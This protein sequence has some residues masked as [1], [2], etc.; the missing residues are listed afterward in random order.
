MTKPAPQP[1]SSLADRNGTASTK[2]PQIQAVK[3]GQQIDLS[4]P[5]QPRKWSL[6]AKATTLALALS[7]LPVLGVGTVSYL[8]NQSIKTQVSK[9]T[10]EKEFRQTE[11][12]LE[13][14]L[15]WVLLSTGVSAVVAG[16]V[17][18]LLVS[19]AVRRVLNAA[20]TSSSLVNRLGRE[21]VEPGNSVVGDEIVALETNVK[22]IERQLPDLLWRQE[23][24]AER[25]KMLMN[26]TRRIWQSLTEADVYKTTTEA[27]RTALK[28]ERVVI[29]RF[30]SNK[31]GTFIEE[32]VAS[33]YS[34][35]LWATIDGAFFRL[36]DIEQYRKNHVQAIDNIY[37][38]GKTDAQIGLW[39]RF[40]IKAHL[41]APIIKDNQLF[42]LLIVHQCSNPREW[43]QSEIDLLGHLATQ[44]GYALK[45]VKLVEQVDTKAKLAQVFIDITQRIRESLN[46]EDIL[47]TTVEEVRKA[48]R[49]E[50]VI[51]YSFD[52]DW[53]GTVSAESVLP[54]FPKALWAAIKDPCFAEGY[55]DKYQNGRVQATNNVYAAGLTECHLKQLEPFGVKANLV[56]PILKDG[57]LFGLLIAHQC[58]SPRDWQQ[59][60]ID[61]FAQ[62]ATQVGFALDHARLLQR[63]DAEGVANQLLA[64]V[65]RRIR[66]SLNQEDILKTTVEEVRKA[67][68]TDRV[69]VY[70]FDADWYGT[71]IAESVVPGYPKALWASIKD[72]CFAE[73]YVEKYQNGRVHA[74]N[75]VYAAGLTACYLKQL[76]PYKVK[77]NLVAPILKDGHLFGLLIAH[78][79]SSPRDWQ[80][81]E[82]DFFAQVATQVGFALDHARL[83]VQVEK[84]YQAAASDSHDQRQLKEAL[85]HQVTKTITDNQTSVKTLSTDVI[86][87][88][89]CVTDAYKHIQAVADGAQ[90]IIATIQQAQTQIGQAEATVQNGHYIINQTL[91]DIFTSKQVIL[92]VAQKLNRLNQPAQKIPKVLEAISNIT[93]QLK[94]Y[95]MNIK[96]A[97][98][99]TTDRATQ[100]FYTIADKVLTS[101]GQLDAEITQIKVLVAQI[102]AETQEV[103]ALNAATQELGS[104]QAIEQ[105][106]QKLNQ[107]ASFSLQM[108]SLFEQIAECAT[109]Q[110]QAST[111]ATQAIIQAASIA[112]KTSEQSISVAESFSKLAAVAQ[113]L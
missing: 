23:A 48:I 10:V 81:S 107:I 66:S 112:S 68:R 94:L 61:L 60:E 36:E 80:Q 3:L 51:V 104:N 57:H 46:E 24:E 43:Q 88:M 42:G 44:V 85:Q 12:A 41:S 91:E 83:L 4:E 111:S 56:A 55:V 18:A 103:I 37:Q 71:A 49:T 89:E 40:A 39:E 38:A 108:I 73:G 7:L 29:F 54:G 1:K 35:M 52:S 62:V 58:S 84:A 47:K 22:Q 34:S 106:E 64:Y 31:D 6:K 109:E 27:V 100:E 8:G 82:I 110:T 16:G 74:I 101:T 28:T 113:E 45:H 87:Q 63:I 105:T 99:R 90:K 67:I 17:A 32:S 2:S 75:N 26:I 53:Y 102:Q 93:S 21:N 20:S 13:R 98:S 59:L 30:D 11:I 70:G 50:R 96:L 15:L 65:T 92:E 19:R 97:T 78:E 76:E 69:L 14:Q 9:A 33:G 72:P 77:A 86:A 79:C 25:S 95:A 5:K